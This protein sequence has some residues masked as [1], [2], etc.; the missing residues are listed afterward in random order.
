MV[1]Q[2][3]WSLSV[4][5]AGSSVRGMCL[6]AVLGCLTTESLAVSPHSVRSSS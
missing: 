4:E 5:T 6:A 1:S 3:E 2:G